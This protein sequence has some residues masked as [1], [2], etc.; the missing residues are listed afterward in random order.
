M[1]YAVAAAAVAAGGAIYSSDQA[2]GSQQAGTQKAIDASNTQFNSSQSALAP[3]RDAGTA[4]LGRL[5]SL[6][7]MGPGSSVA[8][9][10]PID[11]NQFDAQAYLAANPDLAKNAGDAH[12]VQ[13]PYSHYLQYGMKEGRQGYKFGDTPQQSATSS[14]LLSKFTSADL[15][16]DPVYNSGLQFGMD[17]GTKAI[18]RHASATGGYDSGASAK[19]IARFANDYGSTKA[20]DSRSR[21]VEDQNNTFGKLSSIAGMGQGS[22]NIGVS[23]GA[24]NASNLSALY[25]GQGNANA[26]ASIAGGNAI[27]TGANSAANYYQQ[28]Q[29]LQ[30]LSGGGQ[31]TQS[32]TTADMEQ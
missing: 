5:Q 31:R 12:F 27:G 22:T 16:A 19:A 1:P 9:S 23:A 3:Y 8:T 6:L 18:E 7:G 20:A 14:P 21:F 17:E 26:A 10:G 4:A 11:R 29:L 30:Q 25:S 28:Q 15:A 24:N 32:G 2:K 13:D